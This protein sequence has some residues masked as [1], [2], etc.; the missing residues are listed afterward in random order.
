MITR[1]GWAVVFGAAA[2]GFGG[3]VLGIVELFVLAAGGVALV[4]VAV[5]S[6]RISRLSL[7]A[8]RELHPPRVHAGSDSRVEVVLVN[9]GARRTTVFAIRDPFDHGRRQARFLVSPLAPG[10]L[11]RAAYRLPTER[12]GVFA[13]GPLEATVADAFGLASATTK[14]A[15]ETELTVYPHVD[16][17]VS[18]PQSRGHD[19]LACADHPTAV[20]SSGEDFYALRAYEVGDDLRRVH[21]PSTARLDELM[22]RQNEM[23]W[24]GRVTVLLD[25]RRRAHTDE[26]LELA[27][28]A[29][30]SIVT[31]CWQR[32]FLVRLVST[33]GVDS[34]FAAGHVHMETVMEKLATVGPSRDDRLTDVLGGL[35]LPGN[36]GTLV[37]I[38]TAD[39]TNADLERIAR[40][41]WRFGALT[42]VLFERSSY[43]L[44]GAPQVRAR[45]VPGPGPVVR[46]R[47][48]TPFPLAWN[49]VMGSRLGRAL[50]GGPG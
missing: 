6:V 1:R 18:L 19:P 32:G 39:V 27:V 8:R 50:A 24:Q 21:W 36:A 16:T 46:A 3:R 26:S 25:V 33:D 20:A 47:M 2:L 9:Q 42:V 11:A 48:G 37:A 23:P 30:A 40:L 17:I 13:I 28:S 15:P 14:V 44:A 7:E 10:T 5:V 49:Q 43:D 31:A 45:A 41:R 22:I 34:G 4:A 29:A 35:R 38:V 12:R